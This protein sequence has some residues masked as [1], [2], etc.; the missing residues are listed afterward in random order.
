[1]S[2]NDV[3][4][5][6]GEKS[7]L[8]QP[9]TAQGLD[10]GTLASQLG[11][12]APTEKT[13]PNQNPHADQT[14]VIPAQGKQ[15]DTTKPD[16]ANPGATNPDFTKFELKNSGPPPEKE[17]RSYVDSP[18]WP[19][20][21]TYDVG[22]GTL[23]ALQGSLSQYIRRDMGYEKYG[24]NSGFAFGVG[25]A[26]TDT[27]IDRTFFKETPRRLPSAIADAGSMLVMSTPQP[28]AFKAAEMVGIHVLG[29][30]GDKWF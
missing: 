10:W 9:A 23:F 18:L 29:K 11:W 26:A 5:P 21:T 27:V 8:V 7:S 14:L 12:S 25:V 17:N 28:A 20:Q 4:S 1:M 13:L 30:F 16:T 3:P 22:R 19:S 6:H 24:L 2:Q 15:A